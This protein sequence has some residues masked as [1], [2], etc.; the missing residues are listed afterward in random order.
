MNR[1]PLLATILILSLA[2]ATNATIATLPPVAVFTLT[3]QSVNTEKVIY[4]L[5]PTPIATNSLRVATIKGTDE[6]WNIRECKGI[7]CDKISWRNSGNS[8]TILYQSGQWYRIQCDQPQC[9]IHADSI[10]EN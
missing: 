2:C 7:H 1:L 9:W 5:P 4:T 3:P 8:V 6:M 10:K